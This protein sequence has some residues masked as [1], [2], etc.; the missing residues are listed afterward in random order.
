MVC[1]KKLGGFYI[2]LKVKDKS[3]FIA[4]SFCIGTLS[5][6]NVRESQTSDDLNLRPSKGEEKMNRENDNR[7]KTLLSAVD[8]EFYSLTPNQQ[9]EFSIEQ[10]RIW[11]QRFNKEREQ[12][13]K[14]TL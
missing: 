8:Q 4:P 5:I 12:I 3:G 2:S 11:Q 6:N 1:Q 14:E 13:L 7:I 9:A 10:I